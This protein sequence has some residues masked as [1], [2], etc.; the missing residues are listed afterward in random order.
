MINLAELKR[1]IVLI[2]IQALKK[3]IVAG[4]ADTPIYVSIRD[5]IENLERE[6]K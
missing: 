5:R 6:V 4:E 3:A 2:E 1:F